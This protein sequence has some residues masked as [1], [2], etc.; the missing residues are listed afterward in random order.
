MK[1][2]E[3]PSHK[4]AAPTA[5]AKQLALTE[6]DWLK[7]AQLFRTCVI[8]LSKFFELSEKENKLLDGAKLHAL[9]PVHM[10][11]LCFILRLDIVSISLL[12]LMPKRI[13]KELENQ[14]YCSVSALINYFIFVKE[15]SAPDSAVNPATYLA[16]ESQLIYF[17]QASV[18]ADGSQLNK[19]IDMALFEELL[20]KILELLVL[21]VELAPKGSLK[22]VYQ[23][24]NDALIA[25]ML[26]INTVAPSN[27]L[28]CL[29][30]R[31]SAK[32][33]NDKNVRSEAELEK[34][35]PSLR[36]SPGSTAK[37]SSCPK[38]S[39]QSALLSTP[40]SR[41]TAKTT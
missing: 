38:T 17:I 39:S 37:S 2:S 3:D 24:T 29:L 7:Q 40:S 32:L 27:S 9:D 6:Q 31:Y 41:R 20:K 21:L 11:H 25:Y 15:H 36:R 30:L 1:D 5:S 33:N 12:P 13:L 34:V 16:V 28:N 35:P 18:G 8:L 4:Q 26:Y 19:Y 14:M 23:M 10:E 22:G